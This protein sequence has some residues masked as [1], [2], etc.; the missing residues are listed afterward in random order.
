MGKKND[1]LIEVKDLKKYFPVK[2]GITKN[3]FIKAVDGVSFYIRRG[4]TFGLVGESGCGK[5]TLGRTITRLYDVTSGDIFFEENNIAKL[6]KKQMKQY[7]KKIQ[8][9]FQDPYSSLNP[10]MNVKE[11]IE[12]PLTLHTGLNKLERKEKI[13]N[14]L[15]MVGLKKDDMDKFPHEFSGGQCQRIGIARA[16]ST[17]PDFVLCDEPISALDVSIQAQVVNMLEDLQKEMGLTYLFVAHDLS[18]VKHI[19]DRIGVMYLGSIV[20]VGKS[21]DLYKNPLHPYTKGLLSSIP[22]ADPIKAR[23][24]NLNII[25]GD[26]PSPMNIPSGCRFHTRCPYAKP[27]CSKVQPIEKEIGTDHIVACHLY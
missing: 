7:Y 21:D 6:R 4:E 14:L 5:S 19:S 1:I 9:I 16:I 23:Q 2:N 24:S 26:I 22:I 12:E 25:K 18:M 17:N 15:E 11:L 3:N 8:T 13:E 20:E 10:Y 27:I